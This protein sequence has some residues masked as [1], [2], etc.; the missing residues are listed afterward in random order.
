M[1]WEVMTRK[2][3][4]L[5]LLPLVPIG[6]LIGCGG[7]KNPESAPE[8]GNGTGTPEAYGSENKEITLAEYF[9]G[10]RILL[11]PPEGVL[12]DDAEQ[13]Q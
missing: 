4:N 13:D 2:I 8:D 10:K 12:S 11:N 3:L 1:R 7:D 6:F 9:P 5:S